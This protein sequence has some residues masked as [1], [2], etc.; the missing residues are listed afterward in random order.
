V[1]HAVRALERVD[2]PLRR[3]ELGLGLAYWAARYQTLP[4]RLDS[5]QYS[6]GASRGLTG[7]LRDWP[8]LGEME[9]RRGL[10][11]RCVGRL[12]EDADFARAVES[13]VLPAGPEVE[14][15]VD[16]LIRVAAELYVTQPAARVAYVHAVTIPSAIRTLLPFLGEEDRRLAAGHAVQAVGALHCIFGDPSARPDEDEE[17][18]RVSGD[19]DEIRYHA[20]CSIQEHSIKMAEACHRADQRDPHP[21]FALAAA[22]AALKIGGRGESSAC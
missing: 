20:A 9:A 1:A 22:D 5:S 7:A 15:F 21:A 6:E 19:W 13:V 12:E 18:A 14:A 3:R 11:F 10:F 17:T 8:L 2:R 16:A 4:G